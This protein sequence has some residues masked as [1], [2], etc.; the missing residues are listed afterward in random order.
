MDPSRALIEVDVAPFLPPILACGAA[1]IVSAELGWRRLFLITKPATSLLILW[2][3]VQV[4]TGS[5]APTAFLVPALAL[6]CAGDVLLMVPGHG[7]R[8]GLLAFLLAQLSFASGFALRLDG[9][10]SPLGLGAAAFPLAGVLFVLR[11]RLGAL[12]IPVASYAFALCL[13]VWTAWG[14]WHQ[15]PGSAAGQGFLGA[16]LFGASDVVLA[17]RRFRAPFRGGQAL[18]LAPYYAALV[19]ITSSFARMLAS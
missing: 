10:P 7:F 8:V 15:S 18:T 14:A 4:T 6:C 5:G 16:L 13:M 2:A 17:V 11:R 3:A 19:L 9:L 1:A 12:A